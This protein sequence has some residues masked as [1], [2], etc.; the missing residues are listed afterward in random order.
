V[1]APEPVRP[2][3]GDLIYGLEDRPP[4][5]EALFAAAQHLLAIVVGIMTPPAI[6][7]MGMGLDM[8][9]SSYLIS[10]ALLASGVSTFIQVRRFGP[11]GSGL[12]SIQGTS[13]T[14]LAPLRSF[15][16]AQIA[17]GVPAAHVLSTIFGVCF[18]GSVIEIAIS[19][20]LR[21]LSGV[22]T[23]AVSGVIVTLIGLSLV[24]TSAVDICGGAALAGTPAYGAPGSLALAGLVVAVILAAN[25]SRNRFLRMSS[26]VIGL[27]VGYLA[28]AAAG[29]LDLKP[30]A[31]VRIFALPVPFK[32]GFFRF[33]AA[34]FI[35][36]AF[37]YL[38]TAVESI[39]DL[40]ATSAVSREPV[41]G[42]VYLK[43]LAGGVFGDGVNSALA[44]LLNSFPNTTF[45]QNNG[46]IRLT[47]IA[48][49]H[50]GYLIA[51]LLV[52]AGLF[53][54]FGALF[55]VIP[56]PVLGGGTLVMFGSVAVSGIRLLSSI[57]LNRRNMLLIAVSLGLGMAVAL[58]PGM[59]RG[60]PPLVAPVAGSAIITGGLAAIFLN[61]ALPGRRGC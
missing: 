34:A 7:A 22:F 61:L 33:D 24:K 10:M 18:A 19:R 1:T 52:V 46:V 21:F 37:L 43:R 3:P 59:A 44:A 35:P 36:V 27:A 4:F 50:V 16:A 58:E 6:I 54:V 9:T 14:F 60:L 2:P 13:F 40:T 31:G 39:G 11:V 48:S 57:P 56:A 45:S 26:I 51:A 5:G 8:E 30:L 28:A 17:A 20:G 42:K 49:R 12:L 55:S 32:F 53:P 41:E 25:L 15:G 38:I 47:G 23:P 29:R